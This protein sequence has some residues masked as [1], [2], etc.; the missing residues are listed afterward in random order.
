MIWL[1]SCQNSCQNVRPENATPHDWVYQAVMNSKLLTT[2]EPTSQLSFEHLRRHA[3]SVTSFFAPFV[4][5]DRSEE[6]L[7]NHFI[8][9]FSD[10]AVVAPVI[11][12]GY[13]SDGSIVGVLSCRVWT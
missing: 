7:Q 6:K 3:L 1:E 5:S 11:Y 9:N 10:E 4:A 13:A 2:D 12:G 8:F